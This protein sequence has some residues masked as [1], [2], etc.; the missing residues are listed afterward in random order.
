MLQSPSYALFQPKNTH[1]VYH[2]RCVVE[3]VK[4][5][6]CNQPHMHGCS[7]KIRISPR[8]HV[9]QEHRAY[10]FVVV[11]S[12]YL[13]CV[14]NILRY[15]RLHRIVLHSSKAWEICVRCI[16]GGKS[17]PRC[18]KWTSRHTI[19]LVLLTDNAQ[20]FLKHN[21]SWF[22]DRYALTEGMQ[23]TEAVCK[24]SPWYSWYHWCP[25]SRGPFD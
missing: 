18:L 11:I 10:L 7:Q 4:R 22:W 8:V 9:T 1:Y 12:F 19:A 13:L 17:A 6:C 24:C 20:A 23:F 14:I 3:A 15:R 25:A 21:H 2:E 16:F 5:L